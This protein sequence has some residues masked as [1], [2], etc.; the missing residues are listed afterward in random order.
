[1]D[2]RALS[3]RPIDSEPFPG[4]QQSTG[5]PLTFRT[6]GSI[7]FGASGLGDSGPGLAALGVWGVGEKASD[8]RGLGL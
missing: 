7:A 1:M 4:I 6:L 2:S 5:K 8:L 3:Q